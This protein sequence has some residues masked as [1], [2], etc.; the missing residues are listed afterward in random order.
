MRR[1]VLLVLF[2]LSSLALAGCIDVPGSDNDA[3]AA[4]NP[5]PTPGGSMSG[6]EDREETAG[7]CTNGNLGFCATRVIT[8]TGSISG[9]DTLEVD[10]GTFNGFVKVKTGSA[11]SWGLV[12]TL[13]AR[14]ATPD[15]ARAGVEDIEF[16]WSHESAAGHFLLAEASYEGRG[17]DN[18]DRQADLEVTMPP[19]MA[20][21]LVASTINGQVSVKDVKTDGLSASTTNGAIKVD[22]TVTQ[23]DLQTVNGQVDAKLTPAGS[24]RIKASSVNGQVSLRVPEGAQ[25]GYDLRGTTTNGQVD[26]DL[27]DGDV[28]PCPKGS[29]YYT[30]PCN[31][32]TFKTRNFDGRAIRSHVT[33]STVNG[34]VEAGP[35]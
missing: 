31:E 11:G 18:K 7:P 14:G 16:A 4:G 6:T 32:R 24:G 34:G 9:L 29:Q 21:R 35:A 15:E 10:L 25:H 26:I 22:A 13:S 20:L 23:V 27:Q 5:S 17:D 30:P 12:A 19:E 28:G 2:S 1:T 33:L 8:V 3:R